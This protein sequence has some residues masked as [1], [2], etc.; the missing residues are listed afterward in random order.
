MLKPEKYIHVGYNAVINIIGLAVVASQICKIL[1]NSLKNSNT[2][3]SRSS[4]LVSTESTYA[5]SYYSLIVTL[6]IFPIVYEIINA[7]GFK[8]AHFSPPHPYLMLPSREHC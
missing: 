5:T 3:S 1:R 2:Y 7:L 6:D 8:I 4:I